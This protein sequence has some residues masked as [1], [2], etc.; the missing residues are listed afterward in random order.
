MKSSV[1]D[2]STKNSAPKNHAAITRMILDA[3]PRHTPPPFEMAP[4][5]LRWELSRSQ[6][7]DALHKIESAFQENAFVKDFTLEQGPF[8]SRLLFIQVVYTAIT[9]KDEPAD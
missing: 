2:S 5:T 1:P 3:L 7:P 4:N 6:L 8:S 9:A